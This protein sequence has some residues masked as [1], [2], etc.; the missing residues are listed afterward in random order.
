MPTWN[1]L[2]SPLRAL[3]VGCLP[4]ACVRLHAA[5]S[6]PRHGDAVRQDREMP[7]MREADSI[8]LRVRETM[9]KCHEELLEIHRAVSDPTAMKYDPNEP[10]TIRRVKQ[11]ILRIR[12]LQDG[13]PNVAQEM[14]PQITSAILI[15][16]LLAFSVFI[17]VVAWKIAM[18]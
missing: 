3:R 4:V 18:I 1:A 12:E 14:M 13:R 5:V 9:N 7:R 15:L 2:G 17:L 8:R 16:L 6:V 11:L 10:I